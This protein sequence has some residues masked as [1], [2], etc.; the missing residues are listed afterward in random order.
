MPAWTHFKP[1]TVR[2]DTS[3]RLLGD[4]THFKPLTVRFGTSTRFLGD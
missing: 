3:V 1:V 4:W 2:F